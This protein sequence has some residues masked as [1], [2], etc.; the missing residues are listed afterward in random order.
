MRVKASWATV[1]AT[2]GYRSDEMRPIR[3]QTVKLLKLQ[4]LTKG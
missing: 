1:V 2:T 4:S 3:V